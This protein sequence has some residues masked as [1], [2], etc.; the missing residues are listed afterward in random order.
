MPVE[1]LEIDSALLRDNPL[2]DPAHR[3]VPVILPPDYASS[4]A[5]YPTV[6]FLAGF[7]GGGVY[8]L[9]ESLWGESLAQRVERLMASAAIAPMIV[10]VPDCITRLG[11]SQYID[12]TATGAYASHLVEELVPLVDARYRTRA[13]RDQRAVMGKSSGGYGATLLAMRHPDL[14][15][16]AADHSGDKYFEHCYRADVPRCVGALDRYDHSVANFLRDFPHPPTQRGRDWFTLV[17]MLAMASCYSPNAHA[18]GGFD[19][20]FD[21]ATG[22]MRGDVWQRWLAHDPVHLIEGHAAALRTLR[23]YYLDCGRWDEHHLQYGNRVFTERLRRLEVAHH[24]EEFDGGHM[25]TAHRYDLSL[26][27]FSHHFAAAA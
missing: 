11:G 15:G 8:T 2:D 12:S 25:N 22:E 5:S 26:A 21:T 1:I 4:G 13:V 16:L 7:A 9:N 23:F 14:F 19:L 18:P 6:Y 24:Y 3:R 17:N 27:A 20:P 10:V